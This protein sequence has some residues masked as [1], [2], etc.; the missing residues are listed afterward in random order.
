MG[1]IIAF[2]D[3]SGDAAGTM[4]VSLWTLYFQDADGGM[5]GLY[6]TEQ[7]GLRGRA[8]LRA[9][10]ERGIMGRSAAAQ[11]AQTTSATKPT[12]A[13]RIDR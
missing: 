2:D 12:E 6:R 1:K 11:S 3:D 8:W 13:D 4:A 9:A 5:C 7:E 10:G